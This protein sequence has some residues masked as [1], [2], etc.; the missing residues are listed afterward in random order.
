MEGYTNPVILRHEDLVNPSIAAFF[1]LAHFC[2]RA[3]ISVEHQS[4]G[5]AFARL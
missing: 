1:A 2:D 3:K 4:Y 5:V